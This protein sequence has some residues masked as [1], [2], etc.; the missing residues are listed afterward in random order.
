MCT[1]TSVIE[2][3]KKVYIHSKGLGKS[4]HELVIEEELGPDVRSLIAIAA[5]NATSIPMVSNGDISERR[6]TAVLSLAEPGH[7][8]TLACLI[9]DGWL[10]ED[11]WQLVHLVMVIGQTLR[12]S[13]RRDRREAHVRQVSCGD[14]WH[15]ACRL[16]QVLKAL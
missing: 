2:S 10:K 13:R 7:G 11:G 8:G 16:Q 12:R 9:A 1:F 3:C 4:C 6:E 15:G 5:P 14:I